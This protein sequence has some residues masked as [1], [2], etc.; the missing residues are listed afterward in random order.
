MDPIVNPFEE[1]L[2]N[3]KY[4]NLVSSTS[5][6]IYEIH[7]EDFYYSAPYFTGYFIPEAGGNYYHS[8]NIVNKMKEDGTYQDEMEVYGRSFKKNAVDDYIT[9]RM[10]DILYYCGS[11]F[12]QSKESKYKYISAVKELGPIFEEYFQSK[13]IG[14]CNYF[15][16]DI[17][18][19]YQFE[20]IRFYEYYPN[21]GLS[22]LNQS[23]DFK[24]PDKNAASSLHPGTRKAHWYRWRS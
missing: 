10:Y 22:Y 6:K 5:S 11:A 7:Q 24:A 16:I 12:T 17:S 23:L 14:S 21:Q 4:Y 19:D 8:F 3:T 13:I 9:F 20:Q 18:K 2:K 15:E 1:A